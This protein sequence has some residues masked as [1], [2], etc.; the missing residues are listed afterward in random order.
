[1][2][3]LL[4]PRERGLEIR[5]E[6]P[7]RLYVDPDLRNFKLY[8][9]VLRRLVGANRVSFHAERECSVGLFFARKKA[10]FLRMFFDGGYSSLRFGDADKVEL[11]SGGAFSQIAVDGDYPVTFAGV[12]AAE[13]FTTSCPRHGRRNTSVFPLSGQETSISL[14]SL[15]ALPSV[16]GNESYLVSDVLRW[17]GA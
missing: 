1:M 17:G 6:G 5:I 11:A 7:R 8:K 3:D 12:D 14:P 16:L 2:K 9:K 4:L 10:G 13:P 15:M